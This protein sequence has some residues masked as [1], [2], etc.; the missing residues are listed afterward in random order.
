MSITGDGTVYSSLSRVLIPL[1]SLVV[2][3]ITF[4]EAVLTMVAVAARSIYQAEP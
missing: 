4:I 3:E 2:R 1:G